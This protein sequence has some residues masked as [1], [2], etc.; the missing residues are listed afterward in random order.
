[1]INHR[2]SSLL[3]RWE[4]VTASTSESVLALRKNGMAQECGRFQPEDS[5]RRC[6]HTVSAEHHRNGFS[7]LIVRLAE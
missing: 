5:V 2:A 1:M 7:A 3:N 4:E 6:R